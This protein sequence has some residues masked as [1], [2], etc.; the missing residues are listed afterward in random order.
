MRLRPRVLILATALLSTL[1][2]LGVLGC[3][4]KTGAD[5]FLGTYRWRLMFGHQAVTLSRNGKATYVIVT[6]GEGDNARANHDSLPG[7][8]QVV[9]DTAFVAIDWREPA[10]SGKI[11]PMLLRG[12]TLVMLIDGTM[13]VRGN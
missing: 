10:D 13:Y 12:D 4:P 7:T 6:P 1:A 3:R 2:G 5:R 8:Y 11:L 9:G